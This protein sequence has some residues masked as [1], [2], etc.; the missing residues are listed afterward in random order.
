MGCRTGFYLLTTG[1]SRKEV[2]DLLEVCCKQTELI[3]EVPGA[4]LEECGNYKDLNL[5]DAKSVIHDFLPYI[6]ETQYKF[7]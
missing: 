2:V 3:N 4:K 1:M 5:D 7:L 6:K